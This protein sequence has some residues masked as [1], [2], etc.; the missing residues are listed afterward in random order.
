LAAARP[1]NRG[2]R[3]SR[4]WCRRRRT[5]P[6]SRGRR[7]PNC[8]TGR[9]TSTR[10]R[11]ELIRYPAPRVSKTTRAEPTRPRAAPRRATAR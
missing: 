8:L 9:C 5:R 11:Q 1:T 3:A 4:R 6:Q 10:S 7:G 2:T